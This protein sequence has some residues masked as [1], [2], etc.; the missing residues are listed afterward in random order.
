MIKIWGGVLITI[1]NFSCK[2]PIDIPP[3]EIP[4]TECPT[5]ISPSLIEPFVGYYESSYTFSTKN[6]NSDPKC[7]SVYVSKVHTEYPNDEQ[8]FSLEL[9]TYG[10]VTLYRNNKIF[11]RSFTIY[12]YNPSKNELQV[13]DNGENFIWFAHS[14]LMRINNFPSPNLHTVFTKKTCNELDTLSGLYKGTIKIFS[15]Y[16][17]QLYEYNDTIL[18]IINISNQNVCKLLNT[19]LNDTM[20]LT[21]RGVVGTKAWNVQ[22]FW[23]KNFKIGR[24]QCNPYGNA[25]PH[26]EFIGQKL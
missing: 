1:M 6:L 18:P 7:P 21:P 10:K 12:D 22:R 4:P 15:I 5:A 19:T 13:C 11:N 23:G 3:T 16:F 24:Y 8:N 9:D 2:K 26:F 14:G 17:T 25:L 20:F